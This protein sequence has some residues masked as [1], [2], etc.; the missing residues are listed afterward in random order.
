MDKFFV[1]VN[2]Q[3]SAYSLF[4]VIESGEHLQGI[5]SK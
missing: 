5:C 1:Y 2:E 4:N 3:V